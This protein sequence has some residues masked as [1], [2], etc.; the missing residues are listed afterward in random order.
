MALTLKSRV[1]DMITAAYP[2]SFSNMELASNLGAPE[3]SVR[4]ATI[5]LSRAGWIEN[6]WL[7]H[8]QRFAQ[9]SHRAVRTMPGISAPVLSEGSDAHEG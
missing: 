5:A 7:G 2:A 9:W 3:A 1:L 6:V 4:R 8:K